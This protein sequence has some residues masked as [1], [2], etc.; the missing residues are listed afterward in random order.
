MFNL[1]GVV[2][3]IIISLT[4]PPLVLFVSNH[5]VFSQPI[6]LM[7]IGFGYLALIAIFFK[8]FLSP[9]GLKPTQLLEGRGLLYYTCCVFMFGG[10]ADVAIQSCHVR[11]F[12]CGNDTYLLHGEPY[13][14]TPFGITTQ[15]WNGIVHY[16]LQLVIIYQIDN[17]KDCRITTL[18][19][20]GSIITSQFVV[21]V[22]ALS[23]SY[24]D[25]LEYA[26]WMNVIF[27]G[28]PVWIFYKFL[29]KPINSFIAESK[30]THFDIFDAILV[31]FLLFAMCFNLMRGLGALGSKIPIVAY[32][33]KNY[34]PYINEPAQFGSTWVLYTAVYVIPFY[35]SVLFNYTKPMSQWIVNLSVFF[36]ASLLQGT[37]IYLSYT[38]YP[39]S[40]SNFQIP[41]DSL[42]FAVSINVFLIAIAHL[43]MYW[44]LE[45]W[46]Y[47]E[48]QLKTRVVSAKKNR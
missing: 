45:K 11:L 44:C 36:A 39:S 42:S 28:L 4:G 13:L 33:I 9:A 37:F 27:V 41:K 12:S 6:Y 21:L 10:C 18:Y 35:L 1:H 29:G 17:F 38:W 46:G 23:G 2:T 34:E 31:L 32:Y 26:V 48:T 16:F 5:D 30:P 3:S 43:V 40:D 14:Q 24:S 25:S 8:K 47:F 15:L 20:C 22:G 7:T 19:W